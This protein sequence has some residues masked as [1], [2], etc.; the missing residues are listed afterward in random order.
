MG[1]DFE[2]VSTRHPDRLRSAR[3]LRFTRTCVRKWRKISALQ[4]NLSSRAACAVAYFANAQ[5]HRSDRKFQ[6]LERL[7]AKW[8]ILPLGLVV[9]QMFLIFV[10]A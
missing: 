1:V 7:Q 9:A 4:G 5:E 8:V 10:L 6:T 2:W 3:P